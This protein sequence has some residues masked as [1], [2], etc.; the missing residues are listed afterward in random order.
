MV[1]EIS[2]KAMELSPERRASESPYYTER[3]EHFCEFRRYCYVAGGSV[4]CGIF[5]RLA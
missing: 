5:Q 3:P 1:L 2:G 4:I